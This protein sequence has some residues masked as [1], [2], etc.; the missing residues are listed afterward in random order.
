MLGE[1]SPDRPQPPPSRR[2]RPSRPR[3]PAVSRAEF[4][5]LKA[6]MNNIEATLARLVP[7]GDG[8]ASIPPPAVQA[9][10]PNLPDSAVPDRKSGEYRA[11]EYEVSPKTIK[12]VAGSEY[13]D[14]AEFLPEYMSAQSDAQVGIGEDN[15]LFIQ[16]VSK[17][18]QIGTLAEFNMA[19]AK[20][21]AILVDHFPEQAKYLFGYQAM[22][23]VEL[24]AG[25]P[26]DA[27]MQYDREYRKALAAGGD[28]FS[29]RSPRDP[30]LYSR[31][32]MMTQLSAPARPDFS[33]SRSR[34][35]R[36][37]R[38]APSADFCNKFNRGHCTKDGAPC[39]HNRPHRC[40][41]CGRDHPAYQHQGPSASPA[42]ATSS[43]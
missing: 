15:R 43:K 11:F 5:A 22:L 35:P 8:Y 9:V 2:K 1:D 19:F 16:Q 12:K 29:S 18:R 34:P 39:P 7:D 36:N 33:Q 10:D 42:V 20:F 17:P 23:A 27:V 38:S 14:L 6:Q 30:I 28:N 4:A 32:F 40:H 24:K 21:S 13:V 37:Y 25:R 3:T 41:Q 31:L 26:F